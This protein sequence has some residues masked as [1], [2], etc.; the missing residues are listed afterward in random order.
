M[1]S[2]HGSDGFGLGG[3]SSRGR[4]RGRRSRGSGE[5]PPALMDPERERDGRRIMRLF[6]PYRG[7]LWC[8]G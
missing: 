6:A 5:P 3:G 2:F 4:G 8:W 7:R 1:S